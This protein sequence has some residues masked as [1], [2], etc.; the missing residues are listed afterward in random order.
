MSH[1]SGNQ[2]KGSNETGRHNATH[3]GHDS[4]HFARGHHSL[5][6]RNQRRRHAH[7]HALGE[8]LLLLRA[9]GDKQRA[10][11][12]G[13]VKPE[14][15]QPKTAIE[16]GAGRRSRSKQLEGKGQATKQQRVVVP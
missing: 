8:P 5:A 15:E 12:I 2:S 11:E 6:E 10:V 16:Q 3:L 1:A 13:D 7:P 9:S 14:D 4:A